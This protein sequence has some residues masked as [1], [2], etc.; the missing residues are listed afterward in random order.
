MPGWVTGLLPVSTCGQYVRKGPL[1]AL[2]NN[3]YSVI[4]SHITLGR[5]RPLIRPAHKETQ[6]CSEERAGEGAF[7]KVF[8]AECYNLSPDQEKILVAVKSRV[9]GLCC[10]TAVLSSEPS[11]E[12]SSF[13]IRCAYD[14]DF[15]CLVD[16]PVYR[17]I[18]VTSSPRRSLSVSPAPSVRPRVRSVVKVDHSEQDRVIKASV[19]HMCAQCAATTEREKRR[20]R[21]RKKDKR[22]EREEREKIRK[23][24]KREERERKREKNER[25][26]EKRR[27]REKER[28]NERR[29]KREERESTRGG[30]KIERER[31]QRNREKKER[32]RKRRERREEKEIERERES[33][34]EK[35]RM[36]RRQ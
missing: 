27:K 9:V 1:T 33:R 14:I 30:R 24:E 10:A 20:K 25:E 5:T 4:T 8:L 22:E 3:T 11:V 7:G 15:N 31:R 26:R 36:K 34:G 23:R 12:N 19:H 21:E 32:E 17:Q 18:G 13:H 2:I 16:R 29:E 35:E 6:H 28:E